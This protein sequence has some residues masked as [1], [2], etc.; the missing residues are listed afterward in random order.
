YKE[1]IK[2]FEKACSLEKNNL[3]GHLYAGETYSTLANQ[4]NG[5]KQTELLESSLSHFKKA[6]KI[7]PNNP[8]IMSNLGFLYF[9]LKDCDKAVFYLELV[10]DFDGLSETEREQAKA[11]IK[12]CGH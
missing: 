5:K 4:T 11:C 12:N 3:N 6:D 8:V 10:K 2:D 7:N 9:R 1:A